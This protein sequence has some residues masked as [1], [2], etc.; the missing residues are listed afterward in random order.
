MYLIDSFCR[1]VRNSAFG[2]SA[3]MVDAGIGAWL[4]QIRTDR[5]SDPVDLLHRQEEYLDAVLDSS[6]SVLPLI[7][8]LIGL[9]TRLK[10]VSGY[11]SVQDAEKGLTEYLKERRLTQRSSLKLIGAIGS[12]MIPD[13]GKVSTFSTSGTVE[14]IFKQAVESGKKVYAAAFEARPHS[15]GIRTFE[16]LCSFGVITEY[17][18][19]A[20]LH[21]LTPGSAFFVIGAD[22]VRSTGEVYAK[23]GS[24]LAALVCQ[25]GGI[26]FY[27]AADTG[28]YDPMSML[29]YPLKDSSRPW[30]ESFDRPLPRNGAVRN[31]SFE[32]IPPKYVSGIISEK[33]LLTPNEFVRIASG[34]PLD[35]EMRLKL[36]SWLQR[37]R[38]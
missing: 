15:E 37:S 34:G 25:E 16:T 36:E 33:G 29:G 27:I 3:E 5:Y 18:V 38:F 22:A 13:G 31:I 20:L 32:L 30:N 19:D 17:G 4:E 35:D 23:T 14:E 21:V 8:F 2:G 26:P 1:D 24:Y 7:N 12:R 9:H 6:G 11:E 28:K 10:A